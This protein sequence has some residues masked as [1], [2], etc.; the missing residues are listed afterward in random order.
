MMVDRHRAT[1]ASPRSTAVIATVVS[2]SAASFREYCP[3]SKP[4]LDRKFRV[5]AGSFLSSSSPALAAEP[6]QRWRPAGS[7][8]ADV[9]RTCRWCLLCDPNNA[10]R[11]AN[12]AI[13]LAIAS[14]PPPWSSRASPLLPLLPSGGAISSPPSQRRLI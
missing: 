5:L 12:R 4:L 11:C 10:V 7:A 2:W 8:P 9:P 13:H 14:S 6:E 1:A 3:Y